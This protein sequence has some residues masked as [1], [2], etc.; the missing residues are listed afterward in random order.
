MILPLEFSGNICYNTRSNK[1]LGG[2]YEALYPPL[3][4]NSLYR[5][6]RRNMNILSLLRRLTKFEIG[7]WLCSVI[8]ITISF[9]LPSEKDILTLI[10]SLIGV[11]ALIFVAKGWVIGQAMTVLFAVVYGIISLIYGYYG[12]MITYLFMSAP[13]AAVAV[14]SWLR[15]P[16]KDE[17]VVEISSVTK[18]QV[19]IALLLTCAV[20]VL[21]Y[22]ILGALGTA[23]LFVSTL[24]VTTSF[25]ASS[26]TFLRSPYYAL[27]YCTNDIVL[28]VLWGFASLDSLSYLPMV[29]CFVMFLANDIYGFYNWKRMKKAQSQSN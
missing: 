15:H 11:T 20:T 29:L 13:A 22:F 4:S 28:I 17:K 8:V 19:L 23:N 2:N 18:K 16:Y 25:F 27:V 9:L 14:I 3:L 10:A 26:L 12:E 6:L 24:S 5:R 1:I 21:F 7:L